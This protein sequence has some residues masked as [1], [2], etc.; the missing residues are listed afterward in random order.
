MPSLAIVPAAGRAERFGRQKLLEDLGG[1]VMLNRTIRCLLDGGVTRVAVVVAPQGGLESVPLFVDPRVELVLNPDPSRGMFSSIQIGIGALERGPISI[2][3]GD[4]PYVAAATIKLL[5][6]HAVESNDI[7]SPRLHGQRGHPV[8]VP[9]DLRAEILA[10]PATSRLNDVL[11]RH[12]DRFA[13]IEVA[14][15]GVVRDIDFKDDLRP[16]E[17]LGAVE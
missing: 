15:R 13:N 16:E 17:D 9:L 1:E 11:K 12:A 7:V 3:P 4:M 6:A 8:L 14:D 2:L 5:I 10:A